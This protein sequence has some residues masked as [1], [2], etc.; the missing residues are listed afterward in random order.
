MASP[1]LKQ[2]QCDRA[3]ISEVMHAYYLRLHLRYQNTE[4]LNG[5]S[6]DLY[7]NAGDAQNGTCVGC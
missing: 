5:R 1:G 3:G 2:L 7:R 6:N 4:I